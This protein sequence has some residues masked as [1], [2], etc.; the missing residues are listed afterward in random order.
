MFKTIVAGLA[1]TVVGLVA[2]TGAASA[3][4]ERSDKAQGQF[5]GIDLDN[6]NVYYNGK[7]SGVYCLYRTIRV[8]NK[9]TG[10]VELKRAR[11]CG[12]GLYLR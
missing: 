9:R 11:R 5:I 7:N 4:S 10:Y 3:K 2:V 12:R 8:F 6:G 1:F